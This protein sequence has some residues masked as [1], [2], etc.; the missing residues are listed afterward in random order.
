[1]QRWE[2]YVM[3]RRQEQPSGTSE[4]VVGFHA[5]ATGPS[6]ESR[7]PVTAHSSDSAKTGD[8]RSLYR[9][10][11]EVQLVPAAAAWKEENEARSARDGWKRF[12]TRVAMQLKQFMRLFYS[13]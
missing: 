6:H 10:S 12:R 11:S 9:F 3:H 5:A 2:K 13:L 4:S 8:G 1:M 7:H